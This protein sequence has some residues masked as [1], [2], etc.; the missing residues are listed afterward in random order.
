MDLSKVFIQDF[1][2]KYI[3]NKFAD[4]AEMLLTY[5]DCR[6]YKIRAENVCE[7]FYRYKELLDF[8]NYSKDSKYYDNTNNLVVG[9]MKDEICGIPIKGFVGLK[10][11][12]RTFITEDNHESKKSKDIK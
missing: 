6:M 5:T 7:D 8:S 12:M 4:K 2:Y 9:K 1:H 3:K 10:S 11:K